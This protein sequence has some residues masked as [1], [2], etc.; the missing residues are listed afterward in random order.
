MKQHKWYRDA[1][2][3][4]SLY[5]EWSGKKLSEMTWEDT[6]KMKGNEWYHYLGKAKCVVA[7]VP[8]ILLSSQDHMNTWFPLTV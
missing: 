6:R 1:E 3:G 8:G 7:L 2:G 5:I 4:V